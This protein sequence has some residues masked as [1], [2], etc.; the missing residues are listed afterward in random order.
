MNQWDRGSAPGESLRPGVFAA[1]VGGLAAAASAVAVMALLRST[2]QMR[3]IPERVLEWL[4]VFI[5]LDVFEAVLQRYGFDA[6]RYALDTVAIV[7][8][9][10]LA[11][12]GAGALRRYWSTRAILAVGL[13][14]WLFVM[15]V[16]L[17]VTEAGPFASALI[18]GAGVAM[19]GYLTVALTYAG[20]LAVARAILV[21]RAITDSQRRAAS[22]R[23]ALIGMGGAL[24]AL[25]ATF[26]VRR[27]APRSD[28]PIALVPDPQES[29]P[30]GDIEPSEP[31]PGM[32]RTPQGAPTPEPVST[33]PTP[34]PQGQA[35]VP[36]VSPFL[37][38]APARPLKRDRSGAILPSGR[39]PGELTELITS[40]DDFYI[41]SK[42]AAGDPVLQAEDWHLRLDGEVQ[43]PVEL[44]YATLR[45][46][47]AVELTKTLE[48]ISNFVAKC[49]LAPY[50]C[51]LI[52]TARWK[53]VR[54]RDVLALAGGLK[55]S[56]VSL[57][58]ISADEY[59]SA[60]PISAAVDADTLLVYE[61]NGQVLPREHGYPVRLLVP[62][63]YGLKHAKWVVAVRPMGR[64]FVDWYGERQWSQQGIVKSMTRVDV[65][66][67][68]SELAPG[69]YHVAGVAYAGDRGVTS[70]EFSSDDGHSWKG[71]ELLE[72][73]VGR[74]VWVRW[75]G[76]FS[77]LSDTAMT[78]VARM[79]DGTGTQ[80]QAAFGLPQP[81]GATG[82]HSVEVHGPRP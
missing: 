61:M 11:M 51:D 69:E 18:E 16:I 34:Q 62:G 15:V 52:S 63:R 24:T 45:K 13:A 43:Q 81:D 14:L 10:L 41:V 12:L 21:E 79:T 31:H 73:P 37:A 29:V 49:E 48:C 44:D 75:L 55:P 6:K 3:T 4:L 2:V 22:R 64:E 70:V 40:N 35:R 1:A 28:L 66:A 32:V 30:T 9:A 7:L 50:G 27:W 33:S 5:P 25:A 72:P 77:L 54:L 23:S 8:V 78:L 42:N 53:G 60:L 36:A 65:P 20:A 17:P 76:R 59:T 58:A 26:L 47:P 80:Q 19:M 68:A 56:A 74:D 38:P 46:L 71:A 67:P 39:R 82:W 57:V